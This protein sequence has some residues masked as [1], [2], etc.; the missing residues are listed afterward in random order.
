VTTN[1]EIRDQF[2]K[3]AEERNLN[4][5]TVYRYRRWIRKF[6]QSHDGIALEHVE[7]EEVD[8]F[9][10]SISHLSESTRHQAK[11]ALNMIFEGVLVW[12]SHALLRKSS[13]S[14]EK[15]SFLELSN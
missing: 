4:P 3:I 9:L 15:L 5:A 14:K 13:I 10:E 2:L 7:L 1:K 11:N 6:L 12:I 8:A